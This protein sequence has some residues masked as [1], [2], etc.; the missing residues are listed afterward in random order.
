MDHLFTRCSFSQVVWKEV[1]RSLNCPSN[2]FK[3][4]L[5]QCLKYWFDEPSTTLFT[6]F[7]SYVL[8]GL[9]LNRNRIIFG[10]KEGS[11]SIVAHKIRLD[12]IEGKKKT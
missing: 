7:P 9:W 6:D 1:L 2:C 3:D 5:L 4:T 12:Y 8:W 11:L 10:D